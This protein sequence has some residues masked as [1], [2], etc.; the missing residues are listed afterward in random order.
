MRRRRVHPYQLAL[1]GGANQEEA[2]KEYLRQR[3]QKAVRHLSATADVLAEV[4]VEIV[5]LQDERMKTHEQ[6][7]RAPSA[8]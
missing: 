5:E 3:M 8:T 7:F 1:G 2:L 4:L 6:I